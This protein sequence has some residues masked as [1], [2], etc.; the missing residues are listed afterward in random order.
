MDTGNISLE[1]LSYWIKNAQVAEFNWRTDQKN[2]GNP[3]QDLRYAIKADG[4]AAYK[5]V[6]DVIGHFKKREIFTFNLI[7]A[8]EGDP[9]N[10]PAK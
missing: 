3:T 4:K 5:K 6:D 8:L 7:T 9:N 2:M 1:Q 10:P